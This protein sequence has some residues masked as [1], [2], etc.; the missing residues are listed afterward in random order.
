MGYISSMQTVAETPPFTRQASKLF[1]RDE[2]QEIIDFL[3][4]NPLAGDVI[5]GTGGVR[6]LRFQAVGHWGT[7]R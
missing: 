1:A 7:G 5:P 3:A 4:A 2:K 6:K